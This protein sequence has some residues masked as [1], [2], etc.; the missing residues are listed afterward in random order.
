MAEPTSTTTALAA[1]AGVGFASLAP[2]IDGNALVGAF[3]GAALMVI[4]SK[5]LSLGKRF[6]YLLISMAVGY[7]GAADIV[8][9]TPIRSTG[10][11]AF[12]AAAVAITI[13]LE[14]IERLKT[15]DLL[16]L[17]KKDKG[18]KP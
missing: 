15:V 11:A 16:A 7:M 4:S 2:G 3:A 10:V 14:L 5:D 17:L 6:A 13:T 9:V 12:A 1:S 18:G 8:S